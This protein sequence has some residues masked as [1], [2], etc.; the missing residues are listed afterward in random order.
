MRSWRECV[1]AV[2][3][4]VLSVNKAA[5]KYCLKTFDIVYATTDMMFGSLDA[6]NLSLLLFAVCEM[7]V[8]VKCAIAYGLA[9]NASQWHLI[10]LSGVFVRG[11]REC[12]RCEM[13]SDGRASKC[14]AVMLYDSQTT[15]RVRICSCFSGAWVWYHSLRFIG[16]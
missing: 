4:G 14:G 13:L 15:L 7:C 11:E 5:W 10:S 8:W 1:V 3:P 12:L 6:A 2:S 9:I 16:E